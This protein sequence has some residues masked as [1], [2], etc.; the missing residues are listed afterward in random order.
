[1]YF[2]LVFFFFLL[3]V[4]YVDRRIVSQYFV[5]LYAMKVFYTRMQRKGKADNILQVDKRYRRNTLHLKEF[6][7]LLRTFI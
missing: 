7:Y 5:P 6:L 2:I 4:V 1:M 3:S